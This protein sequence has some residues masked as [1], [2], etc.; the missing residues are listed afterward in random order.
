VSGQPHDARLDLVAAIELACQC[1][2]LGARR[3]TE[4]VPIAFDA[5]RTNI[6]RIVGF[7]HQRKRIADLQLIP[8]L[9]AFVK[10]ESGNRRALADDA[11][12]R[13]RRAKRGGS[14]RGNDDEK[15]RGCVHLHL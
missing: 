10:L 7:A 8:K 6:V 12:C 11:R 15:P 9:L 1:I 13:L 2:V 3:V 4:E 14:Q 5:H